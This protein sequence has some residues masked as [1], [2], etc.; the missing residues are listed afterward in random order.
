[1]NRPVTIGS[2]SH[3]VGSVLPVSTFEADVG[4]FIDSATINAAGNVD[5]PG[6]FAREAR[7][8]IS[9]ASRQVCYRRCLLGR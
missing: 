1:M 2:V 9:F 5:L 8:R 6:S 3:V 7:G 4:K